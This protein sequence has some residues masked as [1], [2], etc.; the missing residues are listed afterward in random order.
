MEAELAGAA[1][2]LPKELGLLGLTRAEVLKAVEQAADV[3][4]GKEL[5]EFI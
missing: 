2:Q 3:A 4:D 5:V 1:A